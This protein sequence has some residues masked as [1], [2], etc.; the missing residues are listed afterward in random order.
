MH[1]LYICQNGRNIKWLYI[2]LAISCFSYYVFFLTKFQTLGL[3]GNKNRRV[4]EKYL[5]P[6]ALLCCSMSQKCSWPHT[7]T[8]LHQLWWYWWYAE[9]HPPWSSVWGDWTNSNGPSW[10]HTIHVVIDYKVLLC[11]IEREV[12]MRIK[13]KYFLRYNL[14]FQTNIS[15]IISIWT[16]ALESN[17]S[18]YV[19][20]SE[21]NNYLSWSRADVQ[22][23]Q[24]RIDKHNSLNAHI[25]WIHNW[26][27]GPGRAAI[28]REEQHCRDAIR[29][30]SLPA[31]LSLYHRNQ[32]TK[33][34]FWK[35]INCKYVY[36][37][38]GRKK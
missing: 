19:H 30:G 24:H 18:F 26:P 12:T 37:T 35:V 7:C 14:I 28:G 34:H 20:A 23:G 25:K 13:W 36:G 6:P 21:D 33:G 15:S 16:T 17:P 32:H 31:A 2:S 29:V 10:F 3:R 1:D 11:L 5:L 27:P 8:C 9:S 4:K 22:L 38:I